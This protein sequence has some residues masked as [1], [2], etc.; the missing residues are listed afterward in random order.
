MLYALNKFPLGAR[1]RKCQI[2]AGSLHS[3]H[4]IYQKR[5]QKLKIHA[6]LLADI[7]MYWYND[8]VGCGD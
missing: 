2:S 4:A 5:Q 3:A 1:R 6:N 7:K 8:V